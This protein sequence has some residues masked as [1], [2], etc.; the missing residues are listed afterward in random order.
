MMAL[1]RAVR[2]KVRLHEPVVIS[3]ISTVYRLI[4][5][6]V[7]GSVMV[8]LAVTHIMAL[9][10]LEDAIVPMCQSPRIADV[11]PKAGQAPA[12]DNRTSVKASTK[13]PSIRSA[14]PATWLTAA[15][16]ACITAFL[17]LKPR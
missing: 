4:C 2:I 5:I 12:N 10:F 9:F 15:I 11:F 1:G 7:L 17:F 13:S 3:L 16:F 8:L 6:T 14:F